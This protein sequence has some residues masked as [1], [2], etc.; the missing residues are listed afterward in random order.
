MKTIARNLA[1]H[2]NGVY[3]SV[4]DGAPKSLG[5]T[6]KREA[7][8]LVAAIRKERLLKGVAEQAPAAPGP[9]A[10]VQSA[11]QTNGGTVPDSTIQSLTEAIL[12]L[13]SQFAALATK[14]STAN[15]LVTPA[16]NFVEYQ[17]QCLGR[18]CATVQKDGKRMYRKGS[19]R[20]MEALRVAQRYQ[21]RQTFRATKAGIANPDFWEVFQ[22]LGPGEIWN[23]W[24]DRRKLDASSLNHLRCYLRAFVEDAC[25]RN[26]CRTTSSVCAT[27][28]PSSR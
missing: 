24:R 18:M 3:Y 17:E 4:F 7:K 5:T 10:V 12:Q 26:T 16:I 21:R 9:P 2:P 14:I 11:P 23:Y 13:Q 8:A 19:D 1:L 28:F 6:S 22:K 15:G 20:A 27:R 25:D